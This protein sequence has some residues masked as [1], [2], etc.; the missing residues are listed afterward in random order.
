MHLALVLE[1]EPEVQADL[2]SQSSGH[3]LP[4]LAGTPHRPLHVGPRHHPLRRIVEDRHHLVADRL[5]HAALEVL[6]H[7]GQHVEAGGGGVAGLGI[8]V[9]LVE[10]SAAGDIGVEHHQSTWGNY[11]LVVVL[12]HASQPGHGFG[13]SLAHAENT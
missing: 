2:D 5:D 12:W 1:P 9:G 8:P 4:L 6:H 3:E 10:R 7:L 11:G 13:A